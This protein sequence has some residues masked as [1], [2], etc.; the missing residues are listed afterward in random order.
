M[1][2]SHLYNE[3]KRLSWETGKPLNA[4]WRGTTKLFW[5]NQVKLLNKNILKRT[6]TRDK[7]IKLS[8]DLREPLKRPRLSL[9]SS[10]E[11]WTRELRRIQA[12]AR[13]IT[14]RTQE[15]Q[16]QKQIKTLQ[17]LVRKQH[18]KEARLKREKKQEKLDA[19]Q[20]AFTERQ[21]TRRN[22]EER[23]RVQQQTEQM[24]NN[25]IENL[26]FQDI[27]NIVTDSSRNQYLNNR[28]IQT[29]WNNIQ[30]TNR[31]ILKIQTATGEQVTALNSTTK[32]YFIHLM[33]NGLIVDDIEQFGSDAINEVNLQFIE[34]VS[35][36]VLDRP[37]R[38]IRNRDGRFFPYLNTSI[39]DLSKYQIFTQEEAYN[40]KILTKREQCLIHTLTEAGVKKALINRI[41]LAFITGTSIRKKDLQ[42][43]SNIIRRTIIIHSMN[44]RRIAKATYKPKRILPSVTKVTNGLNTLEKAEITKSKQDCENPKDDVISIAIHSNHY[45]LFEETKYSKFSI[46]NYEDVK[47]QKDF[48]NIV[49]IQI[50][51]K[52]NK[53]TYNRK[54]GT[55]KINSL[56]LVDK[57]HKA[58]KF[59]KLD[60][61]KFA[62]TASHQ[63]IGDSLGWS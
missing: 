44:G 51:K 6:K 61:S 17:E 28:Q 7:V 60:L 46:D 58:G 20:L 54:Q 22:I 37:A 43:I 5:N 36:E 4:G 16:R 56:L 24:F 2:K 9:N 48:H 41:K 33:K 10:N 47:E 30:G 53:K 32:D 63:E 59:K 23:Q 62:E 57:L 29:M 31:Y 18:N 39:L 55:R 25:L 15:Q 34:S 1:S 26:R 14:K 3:A 11:D 27:F 19:S 8:Q 52:T 45:F 42:T 49:K 40:E 35:I 13:R 50:S 38:V 21:T 12:K